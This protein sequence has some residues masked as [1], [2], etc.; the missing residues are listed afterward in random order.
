MWQWLVLVLGGLLAV[1]DF[2]IMLGAFVASYML[3]SY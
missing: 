1:Y 3:A 2:F